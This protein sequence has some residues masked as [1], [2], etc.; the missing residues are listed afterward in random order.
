MSGEVTRRIL[1]VV[2]CRQNSRMVNPYHDLDR[3]PLRADVLRRA[4]VVPDGLWTDVRVVARTASTNDDVA[5]AA[6]A[7]APEG[8]VI[9][10]ESQEAGKG[11]LGRQW[12]SPPRAGIAVSAL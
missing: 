1:T 5:A 9:S 7:G 10:A 6:R 12:T 11:R 2:Q 4:L 8:L 3:P